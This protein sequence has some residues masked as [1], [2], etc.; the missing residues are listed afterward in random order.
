MKSRQIR[1]S[2]LLVLTAF[3]W[4]TAFVAQRE[5]GDVVGPF[6]FNGIRSFIGS[7]VLLPV[8]VFLDKLHP[9]EKKLKTPEDKKRL[10]LGGASCGTILF[11]ASS[12]QQLGLY[13]GTS[14]GK[15]GFLTACYILLVPI[16]SL[17]LKKRCGWNIWVGIVIAIAGLYLLCMTDAF[18]IQSS[19][20][21]VLICAVLFAVHILVVDYFSPLVDGVRMSSIQ[22]LVCGLLSMIP[23]VL[24]DMKHSVAGI[25]ECISRLQSLDAWIPILYAGIFSCGVG[26]TLQIV[27]QNGLNPTIASMLMSLESVFSVFA[28]WIILHETMGLRQMGG[29]ALIFIA[30]LL[31]QIP[32]DKFRNKKS[33]DSSYMER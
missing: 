33:S 6:T 16:L 19:D 7:A 3:I 13:M 10:W 21:I 11:L 12:A 1:N 17:F 26:Y 14:A 27:G 8:I 30:I 28:G 22:F 9:S 2:M 20:G 24:V 5:G 29:C 15:A 4:G 23:M 25:T 18:R 31:A 32:V